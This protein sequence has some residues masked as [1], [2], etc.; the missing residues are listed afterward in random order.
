MTRRVLICVFGFAFG[1]CGGS[2]SSPSPSSPTAPAA[3]VQPNR[4][5]V[6]NSMTFSPAFGIAYL[7][8]FSF[9]AAASDPDG[10]TITYA[11]DVA[12]S[13]MAGTTGSMTF[14]NGFSSTAKITVT[15][16]KGATSSDSRDFTVG[17]MT[18]NWSVTSGLLIG[19]TFTLTQ[20][21]TGVVTGGFVLPGL[22]NGNTDPAQPGRIDSN[23]NLAMRIKIGW[24]TDFNM[25]GTMDQTGRRITGNLQGSGFTG[26]PFTMVK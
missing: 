18:G 7:T 4:A 16:A 26:E 21:S 1:A 14:V 25:Y 20:T 2:S 8:Q 15:D 10:D 9:S 13:P 22:G 3:P 23:G 5:P 6:I 17:S 24:F 12:G 19:S 11:W